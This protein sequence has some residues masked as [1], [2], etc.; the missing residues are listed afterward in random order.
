MP[1]GDKL[2]RKPEALQGPLFELASQDA[3]QTI[4]NPVGHGEQLAIAIELDRFASGIKHH[5]AVGALTKMFI[6]HALQIFG[7][8]PIQV[9]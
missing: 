7:E 3:A 6:Q 5:L 9:L 4:P 1:R 8:L 2:E